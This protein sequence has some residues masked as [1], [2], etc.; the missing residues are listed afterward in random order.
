MLPQ[1]SIACPS[2]SGLGGR[3]TGGDGGTGVFCAFTSLAMQLGQ[4]RKSSQHVNRAIPVEHVSQ[5]SQ[6]SMALTCRHGSLV[7]ALQ[8]TVCAHQLA[9]LN[10]TLQPIDAVGGRV[11]D[12]QIIPA[13]ERMIELHHVPRE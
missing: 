13:P 7:G 1:N 4:R 2:S 9:L 8:M 6:S 10:L 3:R 11:G 5:G 12:G